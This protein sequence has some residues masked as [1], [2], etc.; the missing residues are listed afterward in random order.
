[1]EFLPIIAIAVIFWLLVIRPASRRQKQLSKMQ[2]A[3]TTGESVMLS[4][5][6]FGTVVGSDAPDRLRVELAPGVV[7]EVARGAVASVI[8][9]PV[10]EVDDDMASDAVAERPDEGPDLRK[11]L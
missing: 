2:S 10:D 8:P 7:V 1:M 5:G 4:S 6:I 11:E 3:L 9:D